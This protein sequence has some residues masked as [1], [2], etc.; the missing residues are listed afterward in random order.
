MASASTTA[1]TTE[2]HRL[3]G[4]LAFLI[5]YVVW[6]STFLAILYAVESIPPFF[7]AGARHLIA[8]SILLAWAWWKGERP[9]AEA[10]RMGLIL[11]FLFFLVGHGTLHWAET[12]V[13][14]GVAALVIATEPIFVAW[15]L[16]LFRLGGRPGVTTYLGLGLGAAGVAVLF[17]PDVTAG[18]GVAVGLLAVLLGSISWAAGIVL[19]RRLQERRNGKPDTSTMNAALPL[20][21][22]SGMLLLGG[23]AL[24]E[25]HEFSLGSVSTLSLLGL[26]YL[27]VFGS[28]VAFTAYSWLLKH[29]PPTLVA[30]HTYV[31]P[32]VALILGWAFAG[33]E[34]TVSIAIS[35]TLAIAAI[36][37]VNKGE[38][39]RT[40]PAEVSDPRPA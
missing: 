16:P 19:S 23:F 14:S 24:G 35:A 25:H 38:E 4:A 20:L 18:D 9:S 26:L 22:G 2:T 6:G 17:G 31:N 36:A 29:Y 39:G 11:G 12:L 7:T 28:L 5:V 40:L 3:R 1:T 10:W 27:I 34:I 30:T 13:P 8:G 33:E 32:I 37:L 15:M 21:C